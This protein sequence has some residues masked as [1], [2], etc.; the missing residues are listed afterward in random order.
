MSRPNKPL[1]CAR[2]LVL[3]DAYLDGDL[4]EARKQRV[5]LHLSTCA[6]CQAVLGSARRIQAS[7]RDLPA[8]QA[9]AAVGQRL[10]AA[11]PQ[12]QDSAAEANASTPAN[13][14]APHWQDRLAEVVSRTWDAI[15]GKNGG[16]AAWLRPAGAVA[17][18]V[19]VIFVWA[20]Q[21]PS[22]QQEDMAQVSEQELL[23]ASYQARWALAYL[24]HVTAS[25]GDAAFIQVGNVMGEVI[26]EHVM[27]SV[28]S[29]VGRSM[30]PSSEK[31][32]PGAAQEEVQAP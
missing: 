30:Q 24:A 7:L 32:D 11:L 14:V 25:A 3:L 12:Q 27:G 2:T 21:R 26:G 28:T 9:P 15:T 8:L 6:D 10:A 22:V 31:M 19:L 17:A 29:A 23:D 18:I 20:Q 4:I 5:A 16:A 13:A 1:S